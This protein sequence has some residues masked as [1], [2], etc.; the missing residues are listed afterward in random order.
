M[1]TLLE[2]KTLVKFG[3]L[4]GNLEPALGRFDTDFRI[5]PAGDPQ[6]IKYTLW[7]GVAPYP[8]WIMLTQNQRQV[9]SGMHNAVLILTSPEE[10]ANQRVYRQFVQTTGFEFGKADPVY[11]R[12][13]QESYAKL[14][15]RMIISDGAG[16]K[17]FERIRTA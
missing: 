17:K 9:S 5:V 15:P 11:E 3:N 1:V 2:P 13:A 4:E 6:T 16:I 7:K 14:F 8:Y 12:F 10:E